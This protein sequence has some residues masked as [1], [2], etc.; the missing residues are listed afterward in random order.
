M[1]I[2]NLIDRVRRSQP[3]EA[4]KD[5]RP[6]PEAEAHPSFLVVGLGNP[7]PEHARNRHNIGFML[8]D[9]LAE[10]LD[11]R[12]SRMQSRALVADARHG[13]RRVILV[14]P[15][16][17]M[18]ESGQSVAALQRFYKIPLE[19][20]LVAFDEM[21][22]PLGLIRIRPKGG[23]SGHNGMKSI[24]RRLGGAQGFPRIRLGIGRPP[25]RMPPP[26]YLLQDFSK[27]DRETIL[28]G[29]LDQASDAVL[30][31]VTDGL[32]HAMNRFNGEFSG[33]A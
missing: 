15:Q 32:D 2:G 9:Q 31:F 13:G 12:F 24:I 33:N 7:G 14:K 5:A 10:R 23:S 27:D 28:P 26:A 19:D 6:E 25:G 4:P 18:N 3:E 22:L 20:M 29:F 21:D 1:K 17:Y 16:T 30:A 8:A 11:V